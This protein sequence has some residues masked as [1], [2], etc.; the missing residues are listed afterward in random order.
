[1]KG[2]E[3]PLRDTAY[4]TTKAFAFKG[5]L[6]SRQQL[7]DLATSRS[8]D[9]LIVKLRAT[10]YGPWVAQLQP[11]YSSERLEGILHNHL[12]DL[13]FRLQQVTPRPG[14]LEAYFE[15]YLVRNLK[16]ALKALALGRRFEEVSRYLDL[17]A[18]ELTGRR[19]LVVRVMAAESLAKAVELL[20]G[21][22][23]HREVAEAVELY[24]RTQRLQAIDLRLDHAFYTRVV[25]AYLALRR[26][27][28]ARG[29]AQRVE[30]LV[31]VDVDGY[32]V[33]A[34]LRAKLWSLSR[35]ETEGLIVKPPFRV[36]EQVLAAMV[37]ASTIEEA[38][39]LLRETPYRQL[40]R[41]GEGEALISSLEAGFRRLGY[42]EARAPF[43]QHVFGV[44]VALAL[45]R[46]KELEL[47]NLAAIAIGVE[48]SRPSQQ[49]ISKL[50]LAA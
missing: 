21:A 38:A 44:S 22:L 12:I 33:V 15:R 26:W 4:S 27:R 18:E 43:L 1:M 10:V 13:H 49:I 8:L 25:K 7:E 20:E 17:Y 42:R 19:D 3:P 5:T 29:E 24:Q 47:E 28:E 14:L 40:A 31:A 16:V 6:L 2:R 32:N 39:H 35:P 50:T 9:E 45:I 37:E 46:L 30:P 36:S 34:V 41:E 48:E 11:P 23:Y